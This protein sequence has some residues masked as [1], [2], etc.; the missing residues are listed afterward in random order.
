M[1]QTA[2]LP[3]RRKGRWGFFRPKNP[4]ASAGRTPA[5]LGTKGQH[6][7]SRPPKL[8]EVTIQTVYTRFVSL[9]ICQ[10]VSRANCQWWGK[11]SSSMICTACILY[12]FTFCRT[13]ILYALNFKQWRNYSMA[14]HRHGSFLLTQWMGVYRLC[15]KSSQILLP[16]STY[17]TPTCTLLLEDASRPLSCS[18][19]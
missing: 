15:W 12:T 3:L 16:V 8:L 11:S 13:C 1:G 17:R 10:S 18:N 6:T 9:S 5:N 4:T 2:L 19:S 14:A 7:T